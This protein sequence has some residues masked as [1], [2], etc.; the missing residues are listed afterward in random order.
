MVFIAAGMGGGTGTGAA[1]VIAS[2]AKSL[3]ALTVG[4]VTKPFFFEGNRRRRHAE[5]GILALKESVDTLITIPNERL[6]AIT[7]ES[8]TMLEAFRKADDVLLN[9]VQGISNLITCN[10]IVNV[11]FA[12]VRTIMTDQ[13]LA[14]MGTGRASG[15]NRA[16]EAA[17][18]AV[19]SPL[20]EDV[21]IDGALGILINVT[22]GPQMTLHEIHAAS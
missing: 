7:Q 10:G 12:D 6:L 22:G 8:T 17:T 14:L 19:S 18:A 13:G 20:L 15:P 16:V 4:V 3:G 11:D 9:A 21:S 1:P 2:I 5:A